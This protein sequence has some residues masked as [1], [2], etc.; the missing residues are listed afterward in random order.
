MKR[1]DYAKTILAFTVLWV[2][3]AISALPVN[4]DTILD[5]YHQELP[6]GFLSEVSSN[7][8][9][10]GRLDQMDPGMLTADGNLY[11]SESLSISLTFIDET[12]GFRSQIG[13]FTFSDQGQI[14][15]SMTVFDNYSKLNSGGSLT[16][17]DTIDIGFFEAGTNLGF[18]IV[19]NGD[20][21]PLYSLNSLNPNQDNYTAYYYDQS[22]GYGV[23]GFEDLV[24]KPSWGLGYNDAIVGI[25][26]TNI[27][28]PMTA[29]LM[30]LG[31]VAIL[32]KRKG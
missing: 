13:Y 6:D 9:G 23:L 24:D 25:K 31:I 26:A 4:A 5:I 11:L 17:G 2:I 28:E 7:F 30:A 32:S 16:P 22:S 10:N 27:P 19:P 12:A 14:L 18:Y 15:E 29:T 20:R 8:P 21:T 1:N 3:I